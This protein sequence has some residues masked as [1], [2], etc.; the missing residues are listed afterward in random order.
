MINIRKYKRFFEYIPASLVW[1]TFLIAFLMSFFQPLYAMYFIIIFDLFWL[2]RV[3]YFAVYLFI[4]WR[5]YQHAIK[6]DWLKL[7]TASPKFNDLHHLIVLPTVKEDIE[8]LRTT[9]ES[10]VASEYPLKEKAIVVLAGEEPFRDTF[11]E[12]AKIIEKEFGHH[13]FKFL[14]TLHP[15]G[16]PNEIP[17]KGSNIAWAGR[18][19]QELIDQL[20]I[21]YDDIIVSAFDIDTS[22]HAQYFAAVTHA[23]LTNPRPTRS[24]YQPI[25]LYN[26][27]IWD[28][29][30]LVRIAAF[31]TTFWLM[32]ELSR[33]QRLSTF[34]S[35]SMSFRA[36]VDVGFWE[37]DI[38][39]ED[40]RIFLQ[41]LLHYNGDYS[42][43]PIYVP[44]SMDAVV[45]T[46][47]TQ[48]LVALYKQQ[49]R[50]AWGI[51]HFPYLCIRFYENRHF[52]FKKKL[53]YL[54]TLIEGMYTWATAPILIFVLGRLPLWVTPEYLRVSAFYQNTPF[55]LEK[56]L[57]LSMV[58]VLISATI[59]LTLLPPR[60]KHKPLHIAATMILQWLLVPVTFTI[61]GAFPAID[62][63][64]RL[65]LG[66]YMGY[67][68]TD[69]RRK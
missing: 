31:G 60:P 45:S 36:L 16:L 54:W 21:P 46:S 9:F 35:H 8:I 55:T 68:V 51:E 34:S 18:K 29:P 50:W 61:F 15:K 58:G 67:N 65:L 41:C 44:V 49:R 28:A 10:L 24:S 2:F 19:A 40:S 26:N 23:Y 66:K 30:A 33:P 39:T 14:Y 56:I 38:V 12:N 13:F 57:Q 43:V 17:G 53:F 52:P 47:Y 20:A 22:V 59:S 5:R 7:C 64:T 11:I 4:S 25:A 63:Q 6:T 48:S 27:N 42:V 1:G 37:T 32:S 3:L 62:A 69:K